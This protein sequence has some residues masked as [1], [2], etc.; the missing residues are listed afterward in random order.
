M[1]TNYI[2]KQKYLMDHIRSFLPVKILKLHKN[3]YKK[4]YLI[5]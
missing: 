5:Y 1:T 3:K 2:F 4:Y